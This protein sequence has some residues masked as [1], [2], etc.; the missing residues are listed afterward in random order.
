MK[1]SPRLEVL[2]T[3][4]E[5]RSAIERIAALIQRAYGDKIPLLVGILK[6]SFMFMA[7]LVRLLDIPLQIEFVSL[8]SYGSGTESSGRIK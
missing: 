1:P 3:R 2:F 8:S 4:E 6:G 5:I 7:D